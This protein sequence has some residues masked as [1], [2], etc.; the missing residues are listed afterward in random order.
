[1]LMAVNFSSTKI[2]S[3]HK[4]L[5]IQINEAY[6]VVTRRSNLFVLIFDCGVVVV[7]P[8]EF[9]S[10]IL[11]GLYIGSF[12]NSVNSKLLD[13]IKIRFFRV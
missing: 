4:I 2:Y 1:M 13:E 12:L 3:N 10:L 7:V 11:P 9:M 8:L 5:C 6:S